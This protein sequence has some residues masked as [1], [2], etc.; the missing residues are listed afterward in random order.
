MPSD[1]LNDLIAAG[2]EN[3]LTFDRASE[4]IAW[5]SI[6]VLKCRW[7]FAEEFLKKNP[8]VWNEYC[9]NFISLK[10]RNKTFTF[11]KGINTEQ[12]DV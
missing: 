9:S 11:F 6:N 10:S 2:N 4:W 8:L 1:L 7:I 3:A 12:S 5:Y